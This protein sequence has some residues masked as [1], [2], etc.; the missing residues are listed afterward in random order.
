[1]S[2]FFPC[3]LRAAS[4]RCSPTFAPPPVGYFSTNF[5]TVLVLHMLSSGPKPAVQFRLLIL[6]IFAHTDTDYFP[7]PDSRYFPPRPV[8]L[9]F[10]H[11]RGAR[12]RQLNILPP[13][14]NSE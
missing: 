11:S 12:R 5:R 6:E 10:R 9:P 4:R 3:L 13:K 14:L 7:F 2:A 1:M 8:V